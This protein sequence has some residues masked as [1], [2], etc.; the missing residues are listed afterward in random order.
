M[1]LFYGECVKLMNAM[2]ELQTG[3]GFSYG[4]LASS[5]RKRRI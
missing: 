3:S 5:S 1:S 4:F 2:W